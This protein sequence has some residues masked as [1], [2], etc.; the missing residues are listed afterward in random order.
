MKL[1]LIESTPGNATAIE[2]ELVAEGHEV[3]TCTDEHGGACRGA[4]HHRD[5]PMEQ[6]I[7]MAIV[8][9]TPSAVHTLAEMGSVCATR[10]RVPIVTVD[11][12]E[13]ADDMPSVAVAN[14][15]ATRRVEAGYATAVR[16]EL[17]H[18]AAIVDV[19]RE[20]NRIHVTVQVPAS[21]GTSAKVSAVADR[22]RHAVREHDPFVGGIDIVVVTYPDPTD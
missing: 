8:T 21:D 15:V 16:N 17:G 6:H 7:D 20:P 12:S 14:A 10:H 13:M 5:C 1:L 18:L 3:L 9:R 19:R 22:A 11:P 4:E 2:S